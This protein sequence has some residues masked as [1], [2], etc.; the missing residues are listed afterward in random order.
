MQCHNPDVDLK[1]NH[2]DS[3][4]THISLEV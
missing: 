2:Y 1:Y 3:L 4:K